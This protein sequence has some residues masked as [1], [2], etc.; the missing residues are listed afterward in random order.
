M[1]LG[2]LLLGY[3]LFG[4]IPFIYEKELFGNFFNNINSALSRLFFSLSLTFIFISLLKP[5]KL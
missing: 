5:K 3:S 4:W 1:L 2:I